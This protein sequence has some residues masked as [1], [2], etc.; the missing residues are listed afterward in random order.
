MNFEQPVRDMDAEIRV[1]PD[2]VGIEGR[3][4]D[5]CQRQPIRDDRLTQLLVGVHDDVSGIEEPRLGQMGDCN[6]SSTMIWHDHRHARRLP[7][8][9]AIYFRR[10]I[11]TG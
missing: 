9:D 3:M 8:A 11:K 7:S 1:D 6:R 5:F 4:V 10:R 2:Q